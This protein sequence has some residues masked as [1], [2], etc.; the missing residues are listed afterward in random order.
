MEAYLDSALGLYGRS[1][2]ISFLFCFESCI[3]NLLHAARRAMAAAGF[4]KIPFSY[5]E[6]AR[7]VIVRYP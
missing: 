6:P 1:A 5:L 3:Y 7:A 4:S 2:K